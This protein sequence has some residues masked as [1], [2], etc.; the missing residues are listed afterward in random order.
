MRIRAIVTLTA[1]LAVFAVGCGG[2]EPAH[3]TTAATS[4]DPGPVHV[5]GLG[6]NPADGA[7]LVATHTGLF[8]AAPGERTATRIG[9]RQ[10]DTMGFTVVGPDRFLGSGHPDLRDE[11]PPFLGLIESTDGGRSW[12]PV[13]LLGERDFHVLEA[14]GSHVYGFGTDYESRAAGF[15]A[16]D[17]GGRTW[18][19]RGVPES[20]VSLAVDPDAPQQLVASGERQLYRSIEG[21]RTWR[22]IGGPPGL[23]ARL[24]GGEPYEH[25]VL[26]VDGQ[27][28]AWRF[29]GRRWRQVGEIGGQPAALDHGMGEELLV[30]L[31]DGTIKRST[32]GGASWTI[33]ATP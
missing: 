22:P 24:P 21:G 11:L 10:Q 9:D 27:G 2:E 33:R 28:A 25:G 30:A 26:V 18:E 31:H 8:R 6:V 14:A 7:L 19:E 15:L 20:I 29:E 32:D 13:S 12:K 3:T 16:S 5:H 17:D 4:A 23:L 1:V